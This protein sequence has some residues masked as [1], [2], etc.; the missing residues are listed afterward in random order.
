M[1]TKTQSDMGETPPTGYSI[2]MAYTADHTHYSLIVV[3]MHDVAQTLPHTEKPE[4]GNHTTKEA[5]QGRIQSR[6]LVGGEAVA[7]AVYIYSLEPI[8][9]LA[10]SRRDETFSGALSHAPQVPC[11]VYT[12]AC[13]AI[14]IF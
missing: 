7:R 8:R 12:C 6:I 14:S 10:Y 11:T 4:F 9:C 3:H 13:R 2:L 5:L 1:V